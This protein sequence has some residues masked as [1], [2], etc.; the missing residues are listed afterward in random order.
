MRK[1][2]NR[3]EAKRWYIGSQ[4]GT[5]SRLWLRDVF[6]WFLAHAVK[7]KSDRT[8]N[9]L[10]SLYST[11][12]RV[13]DRL[14]DSGDRLVLAESC[15]AGLV[16]AEL[17]QIPG[18]SEFLCGSMVVYRTLTKAAWLGIS[19]DPL[20]HPD[21]GPVSAQV[22]MSLAEAV[23][24]QTPE[25]TISAAITGHL[26]PGAPPSLDGQ[27]FFAVARRGLPSSLERVQ[28]FKLTSP[29]P[30]NLDDLL[31]RGLRQREAA[32]ALLRYIEIQV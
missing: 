26:G 23:L 16:A 11:I 24:I 4:N 14:R 5:R 32:H 17:G 1:L 9:Q 31:R 13:R 7:I 6:D 3:F 25:A 22:T 28:K 29:S 10:I 19:Q 27:L 20:F 21:I 18:I 2:L 30:V 15:T 12:L 8:V